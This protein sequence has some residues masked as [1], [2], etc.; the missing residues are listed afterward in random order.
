MFKHD[1][2]PPKMI[3]DG[4]KEQVE[5]VFRRKLKEVNCHM[6]VTEPYSPWQQ[7]AEGCIR[8]LK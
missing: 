8:K 4:L 5:G 2:I 6:R 3:L 1:G 7:A